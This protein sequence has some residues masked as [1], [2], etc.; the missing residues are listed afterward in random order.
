MEDQT[1]CAAHATCVDTIGSFTCTCDPG[2][3]GDGLVA[4]N[5]KCPGAHGLEVDLLSCAGVN[6][7]LA[8]DVGPCDTNA[9]CVDTVG[10]YQCICND[11]FQGNGQF[12]YNCEPLRFLSYMSPC[13]C[14]WQMSTPVRDCPVSVVPSVCTTAAEG[15]V[16]NVT[17][18]LERWG[19]AWYLGLAVTSHPV[20]ATALFLPAPCMQ[21]VLLSVITMSAHVNQATLEMAPHSASVSS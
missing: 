21:H 15:T 3:G 11:G 8:S 6:E 1:P 19:M 16:V 2:Y 10:S 17:L 14:M 7:C 4:C 5:S 13:D 18:V 12:C 20:D 9:H